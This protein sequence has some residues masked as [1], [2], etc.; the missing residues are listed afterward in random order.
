MLHQRSNRS[1]AR[2]NILGFYEDVDEAK[3]DES[4]GRGSV[5]GL[6][7]RRTFHPRTR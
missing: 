5:R 1:I 3:R 2:E 4:D 7:T 6:F